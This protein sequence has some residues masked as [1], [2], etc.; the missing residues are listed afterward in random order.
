MDHNVFRRLYSGLIVCL[1]LLCSGA[2]AQ[3]NILLVVTDDAGYNEIGYTGDNDFLTPSIDGIAASGIR[4]T[5]A[6]VTQPQCS[7]SR[8]GFLTGIYEQRFGYEHNTSNSYFQSDGFQPGQTL[9]SHRL[10]ALGYTTGIIGKWHMGSLDGFNRPLDMGFDEFFGLLGGNRHYWGGRYT[11]SEQMYRQNVVVEDIWVNEGNPDDYDPVNGRYVTDAFGDEAVLFINNHAG[12]AEPFFL[13]LSITAP[14]SPFEAKIADLDQFP[15]L[16]GDKKIRAAMTLALDRAVG[17]A[18]QA[19]DDNN[20]ADNTIV[21]FVND[22]GG[23]SFQDNGPFSGTKGQTYEGGIRIPMCLRWPGLPQDTAFSDPVITLD[24]VPTLVAAAGGTVEETDGVDLFPY[25]S[26]QNQ[27]PPHETLYFRHREEWAVRWGNWKLVRP[28]FQNTNISLFD[29]PN[30]LSESNDLQSQFPEIATQLFEKLT[31]WEATLAKPKWDNKGDTTFVNLFDHFTYAAAT[32]LGSWSTANAW[33]RES[34]SIPVSFR[35]DDAYANAIL[36][37][38]TS[39]ESYTAQNDLTRIT[40]QTFML[41]GLRFSG[42]ASSGSGIGSL[43]GNALIFVPSL[44][45]IIPSITNDALEPGFDFQMNNNIQ[46]VGDLTLRGDGSSPLSITGTVMEY[47]PDQSILKTGT[48]TIELTSTATCSNA[49]DILQGRL[50]LRG[51][52]AEALA[53]TAVIVQSSASI[54]LFEDA[55]ITTPIVENHGLLDGSGFLT[56]HGDYQAVDAGT[57][58]GIH[59]AG[60]IPGLEHDQL[61]VDG[62]ATLLGTLLLSLEDGYTPQLNDTFRLVE[63]GMVQGSFDSLVGPEPEPGTVYRLLYDATGVTLKLVC[64]ADINE[65]GTINTQ[66]LVTFLDLWAAGDILADWNDDGLVD[67]RDVI[68]FLS[69]WSGCRE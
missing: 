6:Y 44:D 34:G 14:H 33:F 50:T 25:L 58:L 45:G 13:Y 9:I 17:K 4:F 2:H 48:S 18:L 11:N 43:T 62:T 36:E 22:N 67:T 37:F 51:A 29:L 1:T 38:P 26:G 16:D 35:T 30:D 28:I 47:L 63:A 15:N 66:D 32:T 39:A 27:D 53:G 24:F 10:A 55:E 60:L 69:D 46:F 8:A 20:I 7:P 5:D 23:R 52:G 59:L 64:I 65:D 12:D 68:A 40:G 42:E 41:N 56:I 3:P 57:S 54:G 49:I 21:I 31:L 61:A 19:L